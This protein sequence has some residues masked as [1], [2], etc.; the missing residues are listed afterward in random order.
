MLRNVV[1]TDSRV[2]ALAALADSVG[3]ACY[4]DAAGDWIF[5]GPPARAGQT[6]TGNL[7]NLSPVVTGLAS[8]AGLVPGM[9]VFA[10]GLTPGLQVQSIDSPSQLTLNG[11]AI[12]WRMKNARAVHGSPILTHISDTSDLTPGMQAH[13]PG[14]PP[15]AGATI[16]SVDGPD[17]ITVSQ[18]VLA[19]SIAFEFF[20]VFDVPNPVTLTFA[21]AGGQVAQPVWLVDTGLRGVMVDAE[22]ALDRTS[23][24]N[25]VL[26]TGQ[27][28]A[29]DVTVHALVVDDDPASPTRW[30][31]PFGKVVRIEQSTAVQTEAQ[32]K[33]VAQSLLNL[34]LGLSRSITLTTAPNP[35]LEAGDVITV[36]FKDGRREAHTID[37]LTLELGPE[38]AQ[39]LGVRSMYAPAAGLLHCDL[40]DENLIAT[41]YGRQAWREVSQARRVA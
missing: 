35:A 17:R 40:P 9:G 22:E 27:P 6:V 12:T 4:F 18:P 15:T 21:A 37:S 36:A 34:A 11:P 16:L 3:G 7:T 19:S 28:D 25:G 30:G 38:G 32:A 26:V 5:D 1:Y 14:L 23:T 31:G 2:D 8:T 41:H 10:V 20:Y 24:Y 13:G 29:S 33:T 39:T